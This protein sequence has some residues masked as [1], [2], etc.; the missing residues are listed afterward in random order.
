M[1]EVNS[2]RVSTYREKTE[3]AVI[4]CELFR[5]GFVPSQLQIS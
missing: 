2:A 3:R 1:A 5:V 4:K